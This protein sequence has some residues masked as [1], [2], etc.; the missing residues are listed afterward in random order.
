MNDI[1]TKIPL[2]RFKK[3]QESRKNDSDDSC[4]PKEGIITNSHSIQHILLE[5]GNQDHFR[6]PPRF[7]NPFGNERRGQ[8]QIPEGDSVEIGGWF[9]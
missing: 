1:L 4:S 6:M 7:D 2:V 3:N 8:L 9:R 5:S